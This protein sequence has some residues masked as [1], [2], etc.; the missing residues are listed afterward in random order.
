MSTSNI[1]HY[2]KTITNSDMVG[3]KKPDPKIFNFALHIA[4]A[5][6]K[7]S[8]M[9][10]DSIEADIEGADKIGMDTI[11]FDNKDMHTNHR[12]KRITNLKS[13]VNHL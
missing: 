11:H 4:N 7:E 9:I 1:R 12:F 6:P 2:F 8:I 5:H 10:G 3:V 13:I